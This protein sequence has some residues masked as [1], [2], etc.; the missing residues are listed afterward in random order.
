MGSKHCFLIFTCYVMFCGYVVVRAVSIDCTFD[1]GFCSWKQAVNNA[2]NWTWG[3]G[4]NTLTKNKN[5]DP[6]SDHTP[7]AGGYIYIKSSNK[8]ARKRVRLVTPENNAGTYCL[9]FWY[10]IN[11]RD[12]DVFQI[13]VKVDGKNRL[14]P[15]FRMTNK[16]EEK[17]IFLSRVFTASATF[18]IFL[19]AFIKNDTHH[20]YGYIAV[21]DVKMWQNKCPKYCDDPTPAFSTTIVRDI[22]IGSIVFITCIKGYEI[23]GS[24]AIACQENG[25]WSDRP[26]CRPVDCGIPSL[27]NGALDKASG[28]TTFNTTRILSCSRGFTMIGNRSVTCM[29]D[30]KWSSLPSCV[31]KKST[32]STLIAIAVTVPLLVI[33]I[34][35]VTII[36]VCRKRKACCTTKTDDEDDHKP[37]IDQSVHF[38]NGTDNLCDIN[39]NSSIADKP[40]QQD[41][42]YA[43]IT[44]QSSSEMKEVVY[45]NTLEDDFRND[46]QH[47][48]DHTNKFFGPVLDNTYSHIQDNNNYKESYSYSNAA[49][50]ETAEIDEYNHTK[51][52]RPM[53]SKQTNAEL[54]EEPDQESNYDHAKAG[55]CDPYIPDLDE[56]SHLNLTTT[57]H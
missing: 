40:L 27:E 42:E 28:N 50:S 45:V 33:G 31:I 19:D 6:D 18:R 1:E 25:T 7:G 3:Q 8:M 37:D 49:M 51:I 9:T 36:A 14:N 24:F 29:A 11:G 43:V 2:F 46:V 20:E 26:T 55:G 34:F 41:T 48:Y 5:T 10:F 32:P 16:T 56:Y 35:V 52:S 23:N 44:K 30:S 57:G 21:D 54:N 15:R 38:K 17:W 22:W 47:E 39:I 4:W 13:A 12:T 53:E